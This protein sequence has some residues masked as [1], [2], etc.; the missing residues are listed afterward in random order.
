MGAFT[1]DTLRA[2]EPILYVSDVMLF[3]AEKME[4]AV[5]DCKACGYVPLN[6]DL[7]SGTGED[8]VILGYKTTEDRTDAITDLSVLQMGIGYE[9]RSY[10]DILAAQLEQFQ[11]LA[12]ETFSIIPEFRKNLAKGS[13][14]AKMSLKLL[15]Y[16]YFD[17]VEYYGEG[18]EHTETINMKFGDFLLSDY[19]DR[20]SDNFDPN[21]LA[22]ILQRGSGALVNLL[23]ATFIPA[24][25]D[26]NPDQE[27]VEGE[28]SASFE[29]APEMQNLTMDAIVQQDE[30]ENSDMQPLETTA[31]ETTAPASEATETEQT[32]E[33]TDETAVS[34]ADTTEEAE[35]AEAAETDASEP[36]T[37]AEE[38]SEPVETD[39][40]EETAAETEATETEAEETTE[41]VTEPETTEPTEPKTYYFED[42]EI[43]LKCDRDSYG[44]WAERIG[45]TG[46]AEAYEE[47]EID[48]DMED[49]FDAPARLVKKAVQ[50]FAA[51]YLEASAKVNASGGINGM[52]PENSKT[53]SLPETA[54]EVA[55]RIFSGDDT[56]DNSELYYIQA[57][58]IL[59]QYEYYDGTSVAE[60]LVDIGSVSYLDSPEELYPF[61][62]LVAALTNAQ[63]YLM[64]INGVAPLVM[65]LRNDDS[66]T[67][68]S[69]EMCKVIEKRI[70]EYGSTDGTISVWA[71]IDRSKYSEKY[72]E[73]NT[74]IF[75]ASTGQLYSTYTGNRENA[76]STLESIISAIQLTSTMVGVVSA[77]MGVVSQIGV[78][79]GVW[80]TAISTS[81][82]WAFAKAGGVC[83][84]LLG[85][86][87][88]VIMGISAASMYISIAIMLVQVGIQ[89]Y[90]IHFYEEDYVDAE[91]KSVIPGTILDTNDQNCYLY[92]Y[93]AKGS[94]S[95]DD[96]EDFKEKY[97]HGYGDLNGGEGRDDRWAAICWTKDANAG[98]PLRLNSAG[99]CFKVQMNNS[100][101][102]SGYEA[103]NCFNE[104]MP[105]NLNAYADDSDA[106]PTYLFYLTEDSMDG[107]VSSWKDQM[108]TEEQYVTAMTVKNGTTLEEATAALSKEGWTPVTVDLT[109]NL[110]DCVT[111]LGYKSSATV[112]SA[113]TDLRILPKDADKSAV[114]KQ[115]TLIGETKN[116][117]KIFTSSNINSGTPIIA[118][119]GG[120]AS[121]RQRKP[122]YHT[123]MA[124][125][126]MSYDLLGR[127][128]VNPEEADAT[129]SKQSFLVYRQAQQYLTSLK[130]AKSHTRFDAVRSL[131]NA[132]YSFID[133]N[134]TPGTGTF[135]YLGYKGNQT[136]DNCITDIRIL[137][138]G[139]DYD[140]VENYSKYSA[141]DLLADGSILYYSRDSKIGDPILADLAVL[142][143]Y[144]DLDSTSR[145]V[146]TF[147][148]L[149]YDFASKK[150]YTPPKAAS[151]AEL[152][153]MQQESD[154]AQKADEE[155]GEQ[156]Q[157]APDTQAKKDGLFLTYSCS[158]KPQY[159]SA[160]TIVSY[161]GNESAAKLDLQAQGY[162]ILNQ[163]LTPSIYRTYTYLG[164]KTASA[165]GAA[166]TDLR[167]AP[168]NTAGEVS[169][170]S[171]SYGLAKGASAKCGMTVQGDGLYQTAAQTH[172]DP[173]L[174]DLIIVSKPSDA[175]AGYEPI[176]TFGGVPFNFNK[177]DLVKGLVGKSVQDLDSV[178]KITE[179]YE[180]YREDFP[181]KYV[182][183]RPSVAYLPTDDNGNESEKYIAGITPVISHGGGGDDDVTKN[184]AKKYADHIGSQTVSIDDDL[185]KGIDYEHALDFSTSN[186]STKCIIN[187][188]YNPKRALTDLRSYTAVPDADAL[189]PTYGS[190]LGGCYAAQD[191]ILNLKAQ[192]YKGVSYVSNPESYHVLGFSP[193]H[194]YIRAVS[195][196]GGIHLDSDHEV[197]KREDFEEAGYWQSAYYNSDYS[198]S[199]EKTGLRCKG[200]F[201]C[202]AV[203]G[204]APLAANEIAFSNDAS[205]YE[206][207]DAWKPVVDMRTPNATTPHNLAHTS[208][209]RES[210]TVYLFLK[211]SK[212]VE[213]RYISSVAV[214]VGDT[215]VQVKAMEEKGQEVDGDT[216][217]AINKTNYESCIAALMSSCTDEI[218]PRSLSVV[219]SSNYHSEEN[220]AYRKEYEQMASAESDAGNSRENAKYSSSR[221]A[222]EQLEEKLNNWSRKYGKDAK[223]NRCA[224]AGSSDVLSGGS[225]NQSAVIP[226]EY[227][228]RD[229]QDDCNAGATNAYCAYIGVSR[230]D[231]MSEAIRGMLKYQPGNGFAPTK[232]TVNGIAY[233][234]CSSAPIVDIS[235]TYYLYQTTNPAVGEPIT[236]IDFDDVVYASGSR[237]ALTAA[238]ASDKPAVAGNCPIYLHCKCDDSKGFVGKLYLGKGSTANQ[239]AIDLLNQGA[240][241]VLDLDLEPNSEQ[242]VFLGYSRVTSADDAVYD[243]TILTGE[244][245]QLQTVIKKGK[246]ADYTHNFVMID[247]VEYLPAFTSDGKQ[248]CINKADNAYLYY[249]LASSATKS[250]ETPFARL[251]AAERDRV[252]DNTGQVQPWEY[253]LADGKTKY[254]LNNNQRFFSGEDPNTL[255][256]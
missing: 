202:G 85:G 56:G 190:K 99:E 69:N 24:A 207:S 28:Y 221:N 8:F 197:T 64:Q 147:N 87:G 77:A 174:A 230:T 81:A 184:F 38:T 108:H 100:A 249:K 44:N 231:N 73:T 46:I 23:Y 182:Y 170:G 109:P 158:R 155:K 242:S 98:S 245:P 4:D 94:G 36:E 232:I 47:D 7:N 204:K 79:A 218:L 30:G 148:K 114:T 212:P 31:E 161:Y 20:D 246:A 240:S 39:A 140:T 116:D 152:Q 68:N 135:T 41:A 186:I 107:S 192:K 136:G 206:K 97:G 92:Y 131:T 191:P 235:G 219:F 222:A 162:T 172:G 166:I 193:T 6:T 101:T 71:G 15:N 165:S 225:F 96:Y 74:K 121:L 115:Y 112:T 1:R 117:D 154:Q 146:S 239:A 91:F 120:I 196:Y 234:K 72:A 113:I 40:P 237:T 151:D 80:S 42:S 142:D 211:R 173:I 35:T 248:I 16:Y 214:A 227:I 26:Y 168:N 10:E 241:Y 175:P 198:V 130:L 149:A 129:D 209:E 18:N 176:M 50:E 210:N 45:K 253:I 153:K 102:P 43:I 180:K 143:A 76:L 223:R 32:A 169:F 187:Y 111:L 181:P 233:T 159:V 138:A 254:N 215:S 144:D 255:T 127:K 54:E 22:S 21:A 216:I 29:Q 224:L 118:E 250:Q 48:S 185:I 171:A 183:Y 70:K 34:E 49:A 2:E 126:N 105:A 9:I 128:A 244:Q 188:T 178:Y 160:V 139:V 57:Y 104:T 195:T 199:W 61:Y 200:L 13:P 157:A 179:V 226:W 201:G 125:T 52:L 19:C 203:A 3:Q 62:P 82:C 33:E 252:P 205:L 51:N 220:D 11:Q 59:D 243:V 5:K 217:T 58:K 150:E 14:A 89:I 236:A 134:L 75:R 251:G 60:Y 93:P 194:D 25:A 65:Y 133:R 141:V 88:T 122:S 106:I 63:T 95:S 103:L 189:Q 123:M 84:F 164:Y 17:E 145:I 132:G 208:T 12:E 156:P 163:N 78:A 66:I 90:R 119:F 238:K 167:M 137:P 27:Y 229:Y 53:S 55:L 247:G 83:H 110:D 177:C 256:D 228:V 213:K 37:T 124:F 67:T 86:L